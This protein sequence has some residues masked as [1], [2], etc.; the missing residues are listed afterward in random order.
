MKSASRIEEFY[1]L[2][3]CGKFYKYDSLAINVIVNNS[4]GSISS[5]DIPYADELDKFFSDYMVM[6]Q[7]ASTS[8]HSSFVD[9]AM[10]IG[11]S[12]MTATELDRLQKAINTI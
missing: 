9:D 10:V 11:T 12:A 4:A 2:P 7:A 6:T 3:E 5:C 8:C 1:L